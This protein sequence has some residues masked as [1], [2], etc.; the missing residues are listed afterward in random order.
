MLT[1]TIVNPSDAMTFKAPDLEVAALAMFVISNGAYG[2]DPVDGVSEAVPIFLTGGA[3]Q[4]WREHFDHS[5][6]DGIMARATDIADALQSSA[7]GDGQDRIVFDE[8][9]A[10]CS[11]DA[12]REAFIHAWNADRRT[13]MNDI[14]KVC[15]EVAQNL[16]N[17]S[18]A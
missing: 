11:D 4:W 17:L 16:R 10:A 8:K 18:A 14:A 1:Y 15:R 9:L 3:L 7:Y 6:D 5:I 13:S 12:A 2:A